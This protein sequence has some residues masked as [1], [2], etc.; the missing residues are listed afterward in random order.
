MGRI[1]T[2]AGL[3]ALTLASAGSGC[4][5]SLSTITPT[6]PRLLA[7]ER[8]VI[9]APAVHASEAP[10]PPIADTDRVHVRA[11]EVEG[12]RSDEERTAIVDVLEELWSA[13]IA[14][15]VDAYVA[16]VAP[17]GTRAARATGR[18]VSGRAA[19]ADALAQEW[20][21]FEREGDDLA[22]RL[23]IRHVSIRVEGDSAAVRSTIRVR[24]GA[25]WDFEDRFQVLQVLVRRGD[26]WQILHH[27][28]ASDP[29]TGLPPGSR[30]EL[31]M[32]D[33]GFEYA[34]PVDD[35]AR[36]VRFY[37]A[38]LGE[39]VV[40]TE[41]R[42]T[43]Q[44][45]GGRFH[46]D[47]TRLGGLAAVRRALPN[48]YP[49]FET[50]DVDARVADLRRHGVEIVGDVIARGPDRLAV[51]LDRAG[52]VLVLEERAHAVHAGLRTELAFTTP[53]GLPEAC[54]HPV[55]DYVT[56]WLTADAEAIARRHSRDARYF[57]ATG[58]ASEIGSREIEAVL[59]D[60]WSRRD[61]SATG[62][63]TV[64][65]LEALRV[66]PLGRGALVTFTLDDHATGPHPSRDRLLVTQVWADAEGRSIRDTFVVRSEASPAM[67]LA[68]DY[69]GAPAESLAPEE[70]LYRRVLH[71][72]EP[73]RDESYVG[74]WGTDTVFGI[75]E[76]SPAEDG[77]PVHGR[78]NGYMS[79]W[80]RSIDDAHAFLRAQGASFPLVPAIVSR[81]GI[82]EQP[83]YRQ[84]LAT[85]SEGNLLLLTEYTRDD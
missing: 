46:L 59:R 3:S 12:T 83:G 81:A 55:R 73:Y 52:N 66:R 16:R 2:C 70:A 31:T 79:F 26:R 65:R 41:T 32:A 50:E 69:T 63:A 30:D 77:V 76:A 15:D 49:I 43:F 62:L 18:F 40:V 68:L 23:A 37:T 74:F 80:V 24:G 17:D 56:S 7:P 39:P 1:L 42:A 34:Y 38:L 71:F 27:S 33:I 72:G 9:D 13:W 82:D 84:V 54:V 36:A 5:P 4:A 51:A 14:R 44:L 6:A 58:R 57:D 48:G 75:Y 28:D 85:D 21:A 67:A 64:M 8:C 19:M 10:P 25:H 35:L 20:L 45:A 60:Q 22:A 11:D 78:A 53:S 29:S 47:A 61:R